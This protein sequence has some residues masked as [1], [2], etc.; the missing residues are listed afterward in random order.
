MDGVRLVRSEAPRCHPKDPHCY[1]SMSIEFVRLSDPWARRRLA[2]CV[3]RLA[4]V[5]VPA[6][7]LVEHLRLAAT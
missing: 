6:R 5:P 2:I 1:R 4:A 7:R 3:N